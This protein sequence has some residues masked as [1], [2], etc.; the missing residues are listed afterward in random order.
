M[1]SENW[2]DVLKSQHD[3]L[4]RLEALDAALNENQISDDIDKIL[5]RPIRT[6]IHHAPRNIESVAPQPPVKRSAVSAPPPAYNDLVDE[7]NEPPAS[8][9]GS[10]AA[11]AL[12]M[13]NVPE[14]ADRYSS[15]I[16]CEAN[17][18]TV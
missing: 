14:T 12:L 13:R 1:A 6:E 15:F 5:K 10:V 4:A 2:K 18:T 9:S 7:D 17:A 3:D 16:V 11:D 8:P